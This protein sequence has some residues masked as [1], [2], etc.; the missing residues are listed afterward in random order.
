MNTKENNLKNLKYLAMLYGSIYILVGFTSII[1]LFT[2]KNF[3]IFIDPIEQLILILVGIIFLRGYFIL[4]TDLDSGKAFLFVGTIIGILLGCLAL[5]KLTFVG[6]INGFLY[7]NILSD[8]SERIFL[9]LFNPTLILGILAFI[10][11][12]LI[13]NWEELI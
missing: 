3:M 4:R 1:L 8:F 7:D 10:P 11:H 6:I 13:K 12:K 2:V 5:L 9:Y